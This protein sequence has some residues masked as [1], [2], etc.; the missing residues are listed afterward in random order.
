MT[1]S[2]INVQEM[3]A[4]SPRVAGSILHAPVGTAAPTDATS[5]LDAAFVD[6]GYANED[7]VDFGEDRTVTDVYAWG[8]DEVAN[9]QE[10]YGRTVKFKLLQFLNS[11]VLEAVYKAANV[12][13]TPADADNGTRQAVLL[14]SKILDTWAWVIDGYYN[15][16]DVRWY[17][18]IGRVTNIGDLKMSNKAL[19]MF[20]VTLKVF[21][22]SVKN[23]G[24]LYTDDGVTTLGGS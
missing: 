11:D 23:H 16:A 24:Y 15:T 3:I 17:F 20:D 10:K 4:A 1:T 5:A 18:P 14:N 19:S 22:D 9:L 7:G 13:T 2:A 21:P 12:T 8:G 6:L